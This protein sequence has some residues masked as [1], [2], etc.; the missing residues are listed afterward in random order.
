MQNEEVW[1]KQ[2]R[3]WFTEQTLKDET[4]VNYLHVRIERFGRTINTPRSLRM[5]LKKLEGYQAQGW[6]VERLVDNAAEVGWRTV[7]TPKGEAAP[8]PHLNAPPLIQKA[9]AP[10]VHRIPV[11]TDEEHAQKVNRNRAVISKLRELVS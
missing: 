4:W 1:I 8:N 10:A 7:W 2:K 5:I 6:S 9:M 11:E 3:E